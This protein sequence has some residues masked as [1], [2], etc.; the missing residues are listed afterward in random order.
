MHSKFAKSAY[1]TPKKVL[2]DKLVWSIR[3]HRILCWFYS[4]E[5]WAQKIDPLKVTWKNYL[6][7]LFVQFYTFFN[8]F[9]HLNLIFSGNHTCIF[10][11]FILQTLKNGTFS[12]IFK[13]SKLIL[14]CK[15]LPFTV[16]MPSSMYCIRNW[17]PQ[18]PQHK[19]TRQTSLAFYIYQYTTKW[20]PGELC[21]EA[22]Q[23]PSSR[24]S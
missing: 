1:I 22:C 12:N 3:K 16:W 13:K 8:I 6:N 24:Q 17:S 18:L 23:G 15:C 7:F 20:V 5:K 4:P 9:G 19:N 11:S 14:F 10:C 2:P 21:R